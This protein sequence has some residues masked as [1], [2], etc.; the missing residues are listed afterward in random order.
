MQC[1]G[2]IN[3]H[4]TRIALIMQS[5][6]AKKNFV[7]FKSVIQ[8]ELDSRVVL[9]HLEADRVL[10]CDELLRRIDSYIEVIKKHIVVC[11][12]SSVSS[13]QNVRR[14]RLIVAVRRGLRTGSLRRRS[15]FRK[16]RRRPE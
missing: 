8:V 4:S 6:C 16:Q 5:C 1:L 11:A 12:I 13:A 15:C 2:K 7:D 14:G 10:A 9:Q 3:K